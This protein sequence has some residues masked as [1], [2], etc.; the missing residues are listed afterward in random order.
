MIFTE[1]E[2]GMKKIILPG[3]LK[4]NAIETTECVT[5]LFADCG[6]LML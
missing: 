5:C 1:R 3:L 6:W 2:K 4:E